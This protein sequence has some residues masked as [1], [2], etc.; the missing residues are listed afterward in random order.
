MILVRN[1]QLLATFSTTRS[2]NAT[3][4]SC[5][6]SLTETVLV[7]TATVVGLKCSFHIL[8]CLLFVCLYRF[9][10]QNYDFFSDYAR[11]GLNFSIFNFQFSIY[12]TQPSV[13]RRLP[14]ADLAAAAHEMGIDGPTFDN[15]KEAIAAARAAADKDDFVLVT[16]SIFLVADALA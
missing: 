12:F 16:G 14:V 1:G 4:I 7:V 8:F 2:Q 3:A 11:I 10:V 9:G 13:P 15:V 6:H 5:G